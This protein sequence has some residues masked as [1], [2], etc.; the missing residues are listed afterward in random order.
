MTPTSNDVHRRIEV[1]AVR[2]KAGNQ[3]QGR[4]A[5]QE[6][7][8]RAV[9]TLH[10]IHFF[11]SGLRQ[12]Q[13]NWARWGKGGQ[14]SAARPFQTAAFSSSFLPIT[15]SANTRGT[16]DNLLGHSCDVMLAFEATQSIMEVNVIDSRGGKL[17][18]EKIL[19]IGVKNSCD[20]C[21]Y[22]LNEAEEHFAFFIHQDQFADANSS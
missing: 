3:C 13:D 7:R 20:T 4:D 8:S 2:P 12:N 5:N 10:G 21:F 11:S 6:R 19:G 16:L 9:A 18:E 15:C 1:P 22:I 17:D 14:G